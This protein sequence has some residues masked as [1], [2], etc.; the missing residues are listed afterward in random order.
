MPYPARP[1]PDPLPQFVG[2][3]TVRQTQE[4]REALLS[5]VENGYASGKSLRELAALTDRT[6][7]AVRR[8]LAERGVALRPRGAPSLEALP[9]SAP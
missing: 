8:A 4:Q 6:Q 9:G 3:A 7:T 2:T 1:V 5:F